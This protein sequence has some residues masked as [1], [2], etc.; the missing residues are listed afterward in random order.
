MT[1]NIIH[2]H[3]DTI[4]YDYEN[5]S[6]FF[7]VKGA[8]YTHS[9]NLNNIILDFGPGNSVKGVE[10][11]N[12]AIKFGVAKYALNRLH[13]ID[14][15]L[16]V[17]DEKIEVKI[18]LILDIRNKSI[19]ITIMTADMNEFNIPSGTMALSCGSC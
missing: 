14:F 9:L 17:S 1:E 5:D 13:Q 10:I 4:D 8:D 18:S 16:N 3:A 15:E 6:L 12:A 11:Q 19:P 2:T 7:F